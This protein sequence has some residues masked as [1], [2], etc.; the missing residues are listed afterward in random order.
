ML[1]QSQEAGAIQVSS[2]DAT[3]LWKT[4]QSE[5]SSKISGLVPGD[6]GYLLMFCFSIFGKSAFNTCVGATNDWPEDLVFEF[7]GLTADLISLTRKIPTSLEEAQTLT[8]HEIHCRF[9]CLAG[10]M[11]QALN[12]DR[13][14]YRRVRLCRNPVIKAIISY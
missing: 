9:A 3:W 7:F 4:G 6:S 8:K 11:T 12:T 2:K 5:S 1:I 10:G 13:E 14:D